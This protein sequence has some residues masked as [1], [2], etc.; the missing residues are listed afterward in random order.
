MSRSVEE[1]RFS[2]RE[3][4]AARRMKDRRI[5][6]RTLPRNEVQIEC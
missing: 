1:D 4:V 5:R 3:S 6:R 2:A